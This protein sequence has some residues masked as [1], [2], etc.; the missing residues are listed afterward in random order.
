MAKEI[1]TNCDVRLGLATTAMVDVSAYCKSATLN[2]EIEQLDVT[3]FSTSDTREFAGSYVKW[4]GS[5]NLIN[6][7][8]TIDAL[9]NGIRTAK[10]SAFVSIVPKRP[11]TWA[12]TAATNP[13]GTDNPQYYGQVQFTSIPRFSASVGQTPDLN[14]SFNGS[15]ALTRSTTFV[16]MGTA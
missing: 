11:S 13:V 14:L 9:L 15:G 8:P 10:G 3:T 5:I 16:A 4:G 1:L 12:A 2:D 6:S 7:Y